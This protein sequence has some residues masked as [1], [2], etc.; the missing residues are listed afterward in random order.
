MIRYIHFLLF[1]QL[2]Q[3]NTN[4]NAN[5]IYKEIKNDSQFSQ[6][7]GQHCAVCFTTVYYYFFLLN[8]YASIY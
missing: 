6:N 4:N 7:I 2:K 5:Q 1:I 3:S 8:T